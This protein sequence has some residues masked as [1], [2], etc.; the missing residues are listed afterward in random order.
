M[1]VLILPTT[2]TDEETEAHTFNQE[3]VETH[4]IMGW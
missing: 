4:R 2:F 1:Y 3:I